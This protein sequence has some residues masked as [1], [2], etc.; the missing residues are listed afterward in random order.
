MDVTT[1]M[2]VS[3]LRGGTSRGIF[4]RPTD[5]P[6]A[7]EDVEKILLDVLG[8]PDKRQINGLGG[9]TSVT[10]K[11]AIVGPSPLEDADV[12]YTFAQ[13]DVTR[14]I[15]DWGGNCGNIS[16]AV[17]PFA[18]DT[19]LVAAVEPMTTVRIHNVNTD[20]IIVAHVPVVD[21]HA[22]SAGSYAIAGVP[23]TGA[24]IGLDFVEPGGSTSGRL[25]PTGN[26]RDEVTL[27]DGRIV[28]VS[29]VDAANPVVFVRA[30]D[31]GVAADI[32]P[33]DIDAHPQ[34]I[35]DM[36]YLRGMGATWLGLVDDPLQAW[37]LSPGLPKVGLVSPWNR[38]PLPDGSDVG[39]IG[40]ML[41]MG[42]P[43]QSFGV[44]HGIA[45][46]AAARIEGTLVYEA[47]RLSG[48]DLGRFTLAIAHPTGVM[49]VVVSSSAGPDG[50]TID[51]V[52]VGRTARHILDGTV[53]LTTEPSAA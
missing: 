35:D 20:K 34:L 5:L 31:L 9:A 36:Q 23:G 49:D 19:H 38:Q 26:V 47:A 1:A 29:L 41:S 28:E 33:A 3:I 30:S 43:H 53:W 18:I 15:V 2:P 48:V 13:V 44:T 24:R 45:T 42:R 39:I 10:S 27:P 21:G 11:V 25:L 4:F 52:E 32:S 6:S 14:P 22:I 51:G 37:T 17:G 16:S 7:R 40:R 50:L 12:D 8:S 46:G